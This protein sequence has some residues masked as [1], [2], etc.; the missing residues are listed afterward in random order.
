MVSDGPNMTDEELQMAYFFE[1]LDP[2]V[3]AGSELEKTDHATQEARHN[4]SRQIDRVN[5]QD[6]RCRHAVNG[7]CW[8]RDTV[9]YVLASDGWLPGQ[10][11]SCER[12]ASRATERSSERSPDD[13]TASM[14][15][16]MYRM[17]IQVR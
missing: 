10:T 11:D 14:V 16:G 7:R 9:S 6:G 8:D 2:D 13:R 1:W 3:E 17:Q 5:A 4:V 15:S 12:S